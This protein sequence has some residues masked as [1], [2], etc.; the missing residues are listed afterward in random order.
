MKVIAIA[1]SLLIVQHIF[2]QDCATIAK[3]KSEPFTRSADNFMNLGNQKPGSWDISK[4]KPH[5]GKAET[6]IRTLLTGFTGA[7]TGYTNEYSLDH[8]NG[9]LA[10]ENFYKATGIKGYCGSTTRFWKYYC[11]NNRMFTEDE[12]GSFIYV[13]LNN[14]F[15]S[16]WFTDDVG[17]F[18]VNGKFAF[19][20]LEKDHSEGRVD[21][22]DLRKRKDIN[23]TIYTSKSDIII[24]R[25]SDKPVFIPITRKEYLQQ[26][27]RD[28]EA[29]RAKQKEMLM[30][31]YNNGAKAFEEEMKMY[32]LDKAY[33]PEKEA[34]RRKWFGEDQVKTDKLI[35][36]IDPDVDA[37]I[38]VIK[39]YLQ[40][41][42]EWLSRSVRSFYGYAYT[43]K[44]VKAYF[45]EL[46]D[47]KESKE[48][49]TRSEIVSINPDYFNKALSNDVPQ[50]IMVELI[51]NGYHCMYKVSE[52][53]KQPGGLTSLVA[54]V[55]PGK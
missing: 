40:K 34:K 7:K 47:F 44:S 22:Y 5:L 6:W 39:Q 50:L 54:M 14:V 9:G 28:V 37:S 1:F 15:A 53:V 51:K 35:K 43:A 20:V 26:M 45:E 21:F 41:P 48:D 31:L 33:T 27:L 16:S 46:D 8:V 11:D 10:I 29:N 17:A 36:K 12:A 52:K 2:G 38:E 32:K 25:N 4:M 42:V 30:N 55:N 24:I 23:D 19:R 18:T 13:T 3:N 49:Y